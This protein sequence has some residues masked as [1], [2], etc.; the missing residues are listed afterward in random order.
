MPFLT[1]AGVAV[2]DLGAA[3]FTWTRELLRDA[4]GRGYGWAV[5]VDA[6]R[7]GVACLSPGDAAARAAA[8]TAALDRQNADLVFD[9]VRSVVSDQTFGGVR[10]VGHAWVG[11][12]GANGVT[13]V[14]G[15]ARWEW[16][17]HTA[18][19]GLLDFRETVSVSGGTPVRVPRV[20]LNGPGLVQTVSPS[21][22]WSATQV[23]RSVGLHS[24]PAPQPPLWPA[25]LAGR[26]VGGESARRTGDS[27]YQQF[28]VQWA[29]QFVSGL[30]LLAVPNEWLGG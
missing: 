19:N 29:Y 13:Y 15:T 23:G 16:E 8:I 1:Y 26:T 17:Y 30:P 25:A 20:V 18:T 9:G 3:A 12:P 28:G 4:A 27:D 7:L 2:A 5:A 14:L 21:A 11:S 6:P 10:C 24:R 22:P